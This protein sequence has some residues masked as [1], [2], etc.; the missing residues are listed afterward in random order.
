MK[1]RREREEQEAEQRIR[2]N[3]ELKEVTE[4]ITGKWGTAEAHT[5]HPNSY[6]AVGDGGAAR[7]G[8][9]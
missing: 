7:A 3:K 8:D 5:T 6:P 2:K 9:G 4:R 1:K